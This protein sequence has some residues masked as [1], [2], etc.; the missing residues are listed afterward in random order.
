MAVVELT[1]EN[2]EETITKI[3]VDAAREI[4]RQIRLRNLGGI[5]VMDF[6]D[7]QDKKSKRQVLDVIQQELRRDKAPSKLIPF[8][9]FGLVIMTRKRTSSALEKNLSEPCPLCSG[10]GFTKS[11]ST[12]CYEIYSQVERMWS[13]LSGKSVVIRAN[14]EVITALKTGEREVYEE[15]RRLTERDVVLIPDPLLAPQTFDVVN[16]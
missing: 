15:I 11:T 1:K 10:T 16:E 12:V 14:P 5:I 7:M 2:F 13:T 9:E 6:I 4:I 3:N 8:N